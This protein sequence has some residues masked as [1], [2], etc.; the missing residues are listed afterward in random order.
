MQT[1]SAKTFARKFRG[2]DPAAVDDHIELLTTKQQFLLN[3]IDS[4]RAR[5][6][7]SG[8]EAV[9]LRKEVAALRDTSPSPHAMQHRMAQMLRR[10]VDE[11]SEMQAEARAD[12]Q[13]LIAA[14]EAQIEGEQRKHTELLEELVVKRNALE[15]EYDEAKKKLDAELAG[16][17]AATQ[18]EI[19]VAWQEAQ[20]QREQLL[21][22]TKQEADYYREQAQ[23]AVAEA[24][25]QRIAILEQLTGVYRDLKAVP[26]LLESAYQEEKDPPKTGGVAPVNQ[27]NGVSRG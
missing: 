1:E 6:K 5:L 2:Y 11:V 20:Q 14:A 9:A 23:R 27:T 10:A 16:M 4:L 17:R 21:A 8:D 7:E 18:S 22:D 26:A 15:T 24:S 13:A 19:Q 12:A 3:D 25:R